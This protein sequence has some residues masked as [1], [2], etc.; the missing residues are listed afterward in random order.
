[1]RPLTESELELSER[2][3]F[4]LADLMLKSIPSLFAEP[5][6]AVVSVTLPLATALVRAESKASR[7]SKKARRYRELLQE[8]RAVVTAAPDAGVARPAPAGRVSS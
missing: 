1:M 3:A 4:R 7:N 2:L 5:P 6:E 8:A